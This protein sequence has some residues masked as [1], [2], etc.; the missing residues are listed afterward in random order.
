[1]NRDALSGVLLIGSALAFILVMGMHPTAHGLMKEE[2]FQQTA[3]LGM[4][5]HALAIAATP[6][7]FLGLLG[8]ARRLWPSD[9]AAAALVACG[10]GSVAVMGAALASGFVFPGVVSR[11]VATEGSN[12]PHAFMLYTGL[13][14][15]AFAKVHVVAY[16]VGILLWS[17]AILRSRGGMAFATA[18]GISGI[19]VGI[20]V[21]FLFL[22][23][24][25]HLDV[26][27]SRIVWFAQ[28][29]WLV[30]LGITMLMAP[31][32]DRVVT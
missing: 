29:G 13:W 20:G 11:I 30:W 27:G 4:L 28:S 23:G 1:M 32:D 22:S 18:T 14:N 9:L 26:H 19:V 6:V 21:L 25:V 10:F 17:A 24:H 5:V 2:T 7:A 12:V 16:A 3:R 8:V 15:Q 31:P